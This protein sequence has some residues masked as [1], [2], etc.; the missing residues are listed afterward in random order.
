MIEHSMPDCL[1]VIDGPNG[2]M[3]IDICKMLAS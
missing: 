1:M 2:E 3:T